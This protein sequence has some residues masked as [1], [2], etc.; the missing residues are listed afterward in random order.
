V[1][2]ETR[3]ERADRV[4]GAGEVRANALGDVDVLAAADRRRA[5]VRQS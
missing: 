1:Q 5:I 2:R 4:N 3:A